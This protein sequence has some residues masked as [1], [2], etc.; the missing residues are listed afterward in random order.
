MIIDITALMVYQD[1]AG[2][3]DRDQQYTQTLQSHGT[4][5]RQT[6]DTTTPV[7]NIAATILLTLSFGTQTI[8]TRVHSSLLNVIVN[9]H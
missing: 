2:D 5:R 1:R 8:S 3:R 4:D 9:A 6:G 7:H